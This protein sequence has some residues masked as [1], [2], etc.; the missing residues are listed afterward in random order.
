M[1]QVALI[2]PGMY[3]FSQHSPN[4]G[5]LIISRASKREI[6]HMFSDDV[7]IEAIPSHAKLGKRSYEIIE[8]SDHVIVGGSNLFWFRLFPRA[9]WPLGVTDLFKLKNVTFLGV[10]WGSY[11][12]TTGPFG[13]A[14]CKRIFD[15]SSVNSF[16]DQYSV[17]KA[18]ELNIPNP[19]FTGCQTTW[20]FGRG[21]EINQSDYAKKCIFTLTDYA[22]DSLRDRQLIE[23]LKSF[24]GEDNLYFWPQGKKDQEYVL[25]LN[26][27]PDRI[28]D[29]SLES[30][31]N[32]CMAGDVDYVGTRL[33][34]GIYA[35]E[36]GAKAIIIAVDNRATEM[37]ADLGLTIVERTELNTL[38]DLLGRKISGQLNIPN[39]NIA[40]WCSSLQTK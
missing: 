5:D 36:L 31:T 29:Y 26:F 19:I 37:G 35:M 1:V 11:D 34:G 25:T 6:Q 21:H 17:Q 28:L 4:L 39:D 40:T 3:T 24:Y 32:F 22:K 20:I 27:S 13:K 14:T 12:I 9:S 10:G 18:V 16:R 15:P 2:D 7:Q 8:K 33:H 38:P 23:T 30:F